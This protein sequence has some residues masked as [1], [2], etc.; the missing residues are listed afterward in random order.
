M[1]EFLFIYLMVPP[2]YQTTVLNDMVITE[3]E[4]IK[5]PTAGYPL[6]IVYAP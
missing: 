4:R 5:S 3:L 6:L 1:D 2:I